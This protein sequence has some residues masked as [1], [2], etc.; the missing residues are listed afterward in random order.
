MSIDNEGSEELS[1][2]FGDY[3][4]YISSSSFHF[5][6]NY[7]TSENGKYILAWK[8][9]LQVSGE[10]EEISESDDDEISQDDEQLDVGDEELYARYL[11]RLYPIGTCKKVREE[12]EKR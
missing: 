5:S 3:W 10:D 1:V 7:T 12:R 11:A 8:E 4:I 9:N 2:E 6:G